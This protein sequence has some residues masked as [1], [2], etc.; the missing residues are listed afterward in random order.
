MS[1]YD[2]YASA[3]GIAPG[4]G[5]GQFG[6]AGGNLL[7]GFF[8]AFKAHKMQG[9]AAEAMGEINELDTN[10]P[11]A[12]YR[13]KSTAILGKRGLTPGRITASMWSAQERSY[14]RGEKRADKESDRKAA[15]GL[16]DTFRDIIAPDK[17]L[18]VPTMGVEK[19]GVTLDYPTAVAPIVRRDERLDTKN[20][21]I[22]GAFDALGGNQNLDTKGAL[23]FIGSMKDIVDSDEEFG[24]K[25]NK[26]LGTVQAKVT[27]ADDK[28]AAVVG[29]TKYDTDGSPVETRFFR[30]DEK[31]PTGRW[32]KTPEGEKYGKNK[33]GEAMEAYSIVN[34][35]GK[36]VGQIFAAKGEQPDETTLAPG[37][38]LR[39]MGTPSASTS[40]PGSAAARAKVKQYDTDLQRIKKKYGEE[41]DSGSIFNILISGQGD[42]S[43]AK[44]ASSKNTHL[45][46]LE[47]AVLAGSKDA[48]AD[49]HQYKKAIKAYAEH[50]GY[51]ETEK[52][53]TARLDGILAAKETAD[54]EKTTKD[55]KTADEKA[56]Q[57]KALNTPG[58]FK[59]AKGNNADFSWEAANPQ[60]P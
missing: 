43:A 47:K 25:I 22:R 15:G 7:G 56:V 27:A 30:K 6:I 11:P 33:K 42:V 48:L 58:G 17:T 37:E 4:P 1:Q 8:Q 9:L 14:D 41:G 59:K 54:A 52:I 31:P 60:F 39:K 46:E 53:I 23:G 26:A 55:K 10:M 20:T 35:D 45:K 5:P 21:A 50:M 49:L 40:G 57:D 51:T 3:R 44:A 18:S 16:M 12:E 2:Q 19:D 24:A 13:Q 29:Y 36:V 34:A 32:A 28:N 38:T